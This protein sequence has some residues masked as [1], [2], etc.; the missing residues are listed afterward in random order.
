M[1]VLHLQFCSYSCYL[2]DK[3]GRTLLGNIL[4]FIHLISEEMRMD[5]LDNLSLV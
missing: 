5:C 4:V 2:V 3:D 1:K